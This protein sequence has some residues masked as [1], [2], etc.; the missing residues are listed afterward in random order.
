[1]QEAL[2]PGAARV[3][4][5]TC[6]A[7][8][9]QVW[10]PLSQVACWSSSS[11]SCWC[12]EPGLYKGVCGARGCPGQEERLGWVPAPRRASSCQVMTVQ[13]QLLAACSGRTGVCKGH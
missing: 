13:G 2:W 10:A 5:K 8:A 9:A 1:M 3:E 11:T 7:Q 6:A 4:G 12:E